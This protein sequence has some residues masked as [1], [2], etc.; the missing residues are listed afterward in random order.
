ME[1]CQK[2]QKQV[3]ARYNYVQKTEGRGALFNIERLTC[4]I[5]Q[6]RPDAWGRMLAKGRLESAISQYIRE[7]AL[8]LLLKQ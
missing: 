8:A 2:V 7:N 5:S 3:P 4:V 6:E 1:T